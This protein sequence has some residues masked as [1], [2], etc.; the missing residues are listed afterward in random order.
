VSVTLDF[1][2]RRF[3]LANAFRGWSTP[4]EAASDLGT[5]TGSVFGLIKRMHGEGILEADSDPAPPTRGTQYRL[6]QEARVALEELDRAPAGK[7]E[8]GRLADGQRLLIAR[9]EALLEIEQI[10]ADPSLSSAVAWASWL[11]GSWLIAMQPDSD[12]RA[13]RKLATVLEGAGYRCER[14]RVDE[15]QTARQLRRQFASNVHLARATR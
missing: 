8:I 11:G 4:N 9:G 3:D 10:L 14:G 12:G 7:D 1:K 2:G 13:W 5:E 15:M 6:T